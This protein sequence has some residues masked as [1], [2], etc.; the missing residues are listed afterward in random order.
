MMAVCKY[1]YCRHMHACAELIG[2]RLDYTGRG[3]NAWCNTRLI[4]VIQQKKRS[5]SC[6]QRHMTNSAPTE[7]RLLDIQYV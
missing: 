2:T 3:L 6:M 4:I 5:C 7:I 1:F